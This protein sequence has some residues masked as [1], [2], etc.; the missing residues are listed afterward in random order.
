M[1]GKEGISVSALNQAGDVQHLS[2]QTFQS[3]LQG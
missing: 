3:Q 2:G 1:T